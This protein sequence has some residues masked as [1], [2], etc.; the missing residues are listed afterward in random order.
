MIEIPFFLA[1]TLSTEGI[2]EPLVQEAVP[3]FLV[4]VSVILIAP[5]LS[6][7]ARLPDIIGLILAGVIIG[8][9]VTN[10]LAVD[11]T[12]I[13]FSTVGLIYLMFTAGLEVDLA[14]FNRVRN[15]AL[16]LGGIAFV[17]SIL[18]GLVL[19]QFYGLSIIGSVLL[20]ADYSSQTLVALPVVLR[21][22][23]GRNEVV[24]TAIGAT[25][26]NEVGALLVLAALAGEGSS[27]DSIELGATAQLL[28]SVGIYVALVLAILPRIGR[29][30]LSRFTG[31]TVE[32]QFVLVVLFVSS[33]FAELI[34]LEAIVGAF[35]AGLA[36]NS[37][38][39][40][41]SAVLGR[42]LFVG[43][44]FFIPLFLMYIGMITDPV[45]IFTNAE[46]I[47]IGVS[48]TATVY[49]VK[50]IASVIAGR[51]FN[52]SRDET[53][54]TFGLLHAEA[55]VALA[56]IQVG[57]GVGLFDERIFNG[58]IMMVLVTCFTSPLVVRR[59]GSR[60]HTATAAQVTPPKK[61]PIFKRVLIPVSN[62]ATESNLIGLASILA[63]TVDG[64]LMPL[65]VARY[66][67]GRVDGL[68]TQ[69][70]LLEADILQDPDTKIEPI[71]R[72]SNSIPD[73]IL[74][75][76][77][78]VD[79]SLIV[80]GWHGPTTVHD[81]IFGSILDE[82][83]WNA[84]IPALVSRIKMPIDVMER[85][86][87]VVPNG[88]IASHSVEPILET[89]A[90]IAEA[91]GV[92]LLIMTDEFYRV[93]FDRLLQG[94]KNL[95]Y[96]IATC[97]NESLVQD[98]TQHAKDRNLILVTTQGSRARFQ[99]SLGS[100]P[101]DLAKETESSLVVIRYPM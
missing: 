81:T 27:P 18:S 92:P 73:G 55:A 78:E 32:F 48:L 53:F 6:E 2:T 24:V 97:Q 65:H 59:W 83:L 17:L 10:L 47:A 52:Y 40:H 23:L 56:V 8:P 74:H 37:I 57:Q 64:V 54:L 86:I 12:I 13:L 22:G 94:H 75:T 61:Q 79:A 44:A 11:E 45:A 71:G 100:I 43:E 33:F 7:F 35:L 19:G 62:P 93:D 68:E 69:R 34:G 28:V 89:G 3:V 29:Y 50:F 20:G 36:I 5:L 30:F 77:L 15:R 58:A 76:S 1:E 98:V 101:E 39:P 66:V 85:I 72:V 67:D 88:S 84:D 91:L 95:E 31:R 63:R 38:L 51:I 46:T 87:L 49:V 70:R 26:I 16:A 80:L 96:D 9:S 25:I 60:I 82:I 4:L 90:I 14:L 21:L 42:V 99:S 41:R